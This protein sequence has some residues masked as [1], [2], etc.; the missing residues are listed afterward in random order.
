MTMVSRVTEQ[1]LGVGYIGT[2][3]GTANIY[4]RIDYALGPSS[5]LDPR[6]IPPKNASPDLRPENG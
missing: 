4:C 3:W 2:G 5:T 6:T 1:G